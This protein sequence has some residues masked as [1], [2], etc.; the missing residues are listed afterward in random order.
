MRKRIAIDMDETIC[1]T[2]TR[3]IDWYNNEFKQNLKKNDLMGVKI[4]NRVPSEHLERVRSYPDNP[5]FFMGLTPLDDAIEVIRELS[6]RFD[7]YIATAAMEHPTS[8]T[9]K[10]NWLV[11]YLPFISPMNFVFCGNKGIVNADYLV[12]DSSRHFRFFSGQGV[13]FTAHHNINE[14]AS[15]RVNNWREIKEYFSDKG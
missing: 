6:Q 4:Y 8:F 1:D 13:L 7:I 14:V 5:E 3:H 10:Y 15:V 9:A 2:M 11:E 12:D